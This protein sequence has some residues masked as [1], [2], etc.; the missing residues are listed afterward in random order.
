MLE[1]VKHVRKK[2]EENKNGEGNKVVGGDFLSLFLDQA[3]KEETDVPD[4]LLADIALNLLFAG[5]DTTGSALAWMFFE[6]S[7][8]PDVLAKAR[9][10]IEKFAPK[11]RDLTFDDLKHLQYLTWIQYETLRLHPSIPTD[12]R[13]SKNDCVLPDGTFVRYKMN[14]FHTYKLKIQM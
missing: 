12:P 13:Y 4:E 10:E 1:I 2:F 3:K 9:A 8:H 6:L 11:D 7:Q 5:R 14:L